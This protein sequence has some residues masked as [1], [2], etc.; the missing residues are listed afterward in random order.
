MKNLKTFKS[1]SINESKKL[2][3][4]E[5]NYIMSNNID[6]EGENQDKYTDEQRHQVLVYAFGDEFVASEDKGSLKTY[7]EDEDED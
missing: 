1:F 4:E 2:T 7:E 3:I 6:M 5:M